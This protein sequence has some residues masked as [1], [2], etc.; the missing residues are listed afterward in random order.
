MSDRTQALRQFLDDAN[1]AEI[2]PVPLAGDASA[3]RYFRIAGAPS[4]ILMDA[5]PA[6]DQNTDGFVQIAAHLRSVGLNA[7]RV[8]KIDLA[9]G[10]LLLEDFGDGDFASVIGS[11][12]EMELPLYRAALEVLIALENTAPPDGLPRYTAR[13]MAEIVSPAFEWYGMTEDQSDSDVRLI[14]ELMEHALAPL[15]MTV[16]GL[17]DFHAENLM[18]LPERVG[19]E[20]VALLDFQDA[21]I[22]PPCY[23]LVSLLQDARRDVSPQTIDTIQ[24]EFAEMTGRDLR[25]VTSA[26]AVVGLQRNLR[27]MGIFARL[28][29]TQGKPRYL[30]F[31]PRVWRYV[32]QCLTDPYLSEISRVV[33]RTLQPPTSDV[34]TD[35]RRRCRTVHEQ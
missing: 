31:L 17:R 32:E 2:E 29:L 6:A 8:L 23:D 14:Q 27:I 9:K 12:P 21:M 26:C 15:P 24:A 28:A 35:L 20:R 16:Y 30:D 4:M 7:P 3:R 33:R 5:P 25:E 1:L 19:L 11:A 10:F 34:I 22:G 13:S 18:W